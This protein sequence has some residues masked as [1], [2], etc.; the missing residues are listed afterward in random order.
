[1]KYLINILIFSIEIYFRMSFYVS[2]IGSIDR[3]SFMAS[4]TFAAIS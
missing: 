3:Y 2:D 4:S 1:M